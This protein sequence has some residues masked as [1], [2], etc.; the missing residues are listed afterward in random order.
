MHD[1]TH[2]PVKLLAA[3]ECAVTTFVRENPDSGED[4]TLEKGV[5]APGEESQGGV[6]EHGDE[7]DR[8]VYQH[9]DVEVVA[10][11]VGH[12]TESGWLETVGWN[13]IVDLLHGEVRKLEDVAMKI[14]MLS[15]LGGRLGGCCSHSW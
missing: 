4:Q 15:L 2:G 1:K 11:N 7:C 13:G 6:G 8:K 10:H 14:D 5:R 12:T 9:T 3:G